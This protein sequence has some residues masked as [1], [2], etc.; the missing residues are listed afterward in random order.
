MVIN[1]KHR[2]SSLSDSQCCVSLAS[3]FSLPE[4]I[5]VLDLDT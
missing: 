1:E 3:F 2:T 5:N 4:D